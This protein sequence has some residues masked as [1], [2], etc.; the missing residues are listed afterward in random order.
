[1]PVTL[2]DIKQAAA[3]IK[4]A[5]E[6]TPCHRSRTLS[7]LTGAD[8]YLKFENLQFTASFKERGAVNK[9][10]SLTPEERRRGVI[11]MS[12]GNHA[13]GVAYHATRLGI[14]STIVMPETTPY[15]K[16][17]YTLAH[18]A[19]VIQK[20]MTLADCDH[21]AHEIAAKEGL[22][23]VHPYDDDKIIAG[24]GTVALEMLE[25]FPEIDTLVVP[26]GG[27]GLIAGMAI[28]AR[29]MKPGVRMVGVETRLFPSMYNALKHGN[30]PIGGR[31]IAEGIA[32]KNVGAKTTEI[33]GRLLDDVLLVSEE[34]I[35]RA[36]A[37]LLAIEK[38]V[39]EGAGAAG[40]AAMLQHPEQFAG[41]KVGLVLCGGNIDPRLLSNVIM[42]ELQR[43]GRILTIAVE[44]EDRPG[45]LAKV[46]T[47]VGDA[48]GN[49]IE[50]AHNR[51][52][53]DMPAKDAELRISLETR[54]AAHAQAICQ[55]VRDAGYIVHVL[56]T[57]VQH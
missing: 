16:V 43:E 29:A 55:A 54:D 57:T 31:T 30:E 42:R 37:L 2:E 4:G 52:L 32:V 41:R 13:Q 3:L 35:E 21:I 47:L 48:G 56:G 17:K 26:V 7:Q 44:I 34:S 23:F 27:G 1:M 6:R 8:V 53:T 9:L 39:V 50:V 15:V 51:M 19:R 22:V 36:I 46:A 40:F 14:P 49:I 20:G 11:A 25:D 45:I 18:G 33:C 12:A 5:V 24:T 28:A 38:S 10:T